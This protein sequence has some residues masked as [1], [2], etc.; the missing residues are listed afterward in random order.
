MENNNPLKTKRTTRAVQSPLP[1]Q[2]LPGEFEYEIEYANDLETLNN[3][4]MGIGQPGNVP[5]PCT[6]FIF[7]VMNDIGYSSINPPVTQMIGDDFNYF[8]GFLD[9]GNNKINL[10]ID[11]SSSPNINQNVGLFSRI[12]NGAISRLAIE[13]S[14]TGGLHSQYVGGFAGQVESGRLHFVTNLADVTGISPTSSV[15]GITGAVSGTPPPFH[16]CCNNGTII[17]GLYVAG[18][19]GSVNYVSSCHTHRLK[20][21]GTIKG[22]E[23]T[24][25]NCMAGI[26]AYS[27]TSYTHLHLAVNI[28]RV[29][30]SNSAYS[31]GLIA[32]LDN[33]V[34]VRGFNAGIVYGG[35][36]VGGVAGYLGDVVF[37]Q[38][39]NA[40]WVERG[41]A[42]NF[43]A[44]AGLVAGGTIF[45]NYYD[46]QMCIWGAINNQAPPPGQATGLPT[47]QMI[48][49]NLSFASFNPYPQLYPIFYI[50]P[51]ELLAGAPIYL[52]VNDDLDNVRNTF[53]V[54]NENST[55]PFL[56]PPN[57][58]FP[59]QWGS[60][61]D[62][63]VPWIHIPNSVMGYV[64]VPAPPSNIANIVGRGQDTLVVRV[65]GYIPPPTYNNYYDAIYEK[66]VPLNVR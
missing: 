14:V 56:P 10:D 29:L 53:Y 27:A 59:Y 61:D 41:F 64:N 20:N 26:I 51:I 5:E 38:N 28:G 34:V 33:G 52:D 25:Q 9:G 57:I 21:S 12:L 60:F 62:S 8:S 48:G 50:H 47:R 58:P 30:G 13:G 32:R 35:S 36:I 15:G 45:D 11:L 54:S 37:G 55:P 17:G 31:G 4:V 3:W 23:G 65:D 63:V 1:P 19:I 22:I 66:V 43:G 6:G 49:T 18:C 24:H 7:R 40:N 16:D 42:Q 46:N 39:I 44:I 2:P